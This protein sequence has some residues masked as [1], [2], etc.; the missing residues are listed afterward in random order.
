[1]CDYLREEQKLKMKIKILKIFAK[2]L[3]NAAPN[4]VTP[5]VKS[6]AIKA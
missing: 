5:H 1:M 6:D 4:A 2:N 3:P